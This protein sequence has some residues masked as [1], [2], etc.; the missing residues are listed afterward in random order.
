[1][2]RLTNM[3]VFTQVVESKSFTGAAEKLGMTR[4]GVS[5]S[6]QQ[7]EKQLGARLLN[8]T[9]RR[10][11]PTEVGLAYHDR[12]VAIL[13]DV[14]EAERAV[15]SLHDEP[16][17]RLRINAPMSFAMLHLAEPLNDFMERYAEV[18]VQLIMND[19]QVDMIDGGFDIG[20]R[21]GA[22]ADSSMIARRIGV[23]HNALV[24]SP[25]YVAAHGE[26]QHPDD[27]MEHTCLTY[28]HLATDVRWR[29]KKASTEVT[30]TVPGHLCVNNGDVLRDAAVRGRGI[31]LLPTFISGDD[32]RAGKLVRL[33]P[34]WEREPADI[35]VIYP[36][37]RYLSAK[38]RVFID[39]LAQRFGDQPYWDEGLEPYSAASS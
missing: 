7:L 14:D 11:S 1:M 37:H 18:Q 9:T 2:D 30:V 15:S 8:R 13:A 27:L 28:G 32:L 12:C 31:V 19:R 4:A 6:V 35:S 21:I 10:V 23:S 26:P 38:V 22:L 36:P 25:D 20:V 29:F 39:F 17:G 16:R 3:R 34:G 5:K 24:A 33:L